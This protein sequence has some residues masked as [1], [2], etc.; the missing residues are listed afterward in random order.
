MS[1]LRSLFGD[2]HLVTIRGRP[3]LIGLRLLKANIES[4]GL[5]SVVEVAEVALG[6]SEG[7]GTLGVSSS[8]KGDHRILVDSSADKGRARGE[9]ADRG[10]G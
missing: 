2:T 10:V 6:A 5:S 8:Q 7:I 1:M 4:R 3:F 9:R